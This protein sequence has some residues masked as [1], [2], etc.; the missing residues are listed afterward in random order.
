MT[1]SRN[2]A[3]GRGEMP[4]PDCSSEHGAV[5]DYS[6]QHDSSNAEQQSADIV[7]PAADTT[8]FTLFCWT[9]KQMLRGV[10]ELLWVYLSRLALCWL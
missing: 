3:L 2:R 4:S 8:I 7:E 10:L 6:F 9:I 1:G 5:T